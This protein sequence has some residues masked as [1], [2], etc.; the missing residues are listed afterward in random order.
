MSKSVC[1]LLAAGMAL[2]AS[3]SIADAAVV[4]DLR[5]AQIEQEIRELKQQVAQQA[6]RIE[7]LEMERTQARVFPADRSKH[8]AQSDRD[9]QADEPS[10]WLRASNWEKIRSGMSE[11]SV[12][13]TLGP[14][15]TLRKSDDGSRQTLFYA[16]ELGAGSFLTGRVTMAGGK[17]VDVEAP[18]LK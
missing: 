18:K 15:T 4:D 6:R 13:E 8:L 7:T 9:R 17:V 3:I 14:P 1:R 2:A 5:I 12:I 10:K 16:M 11:L